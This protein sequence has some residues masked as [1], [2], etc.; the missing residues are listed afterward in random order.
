MGDELRFYYSGADKAT[1]YATLRR[2]GFCSVQ[3]GK[4][5]TKPLMFSK[6]DRLWVNA[7][8]RQGELTLRIVGQNGKNFGE[9]KIS[10]KDAM[11][12]DVGVV[13]ANNPFTLVFISTGGAKLYS[14]WIGGADG[15]F[16]DMHFC[17]P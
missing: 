10:G 3:D 2:D 7:D 17:N 15:G 5:R 4:I 16:M 13:E 9:C 1:G 8:T 6:G 12:I 11:H 14:F